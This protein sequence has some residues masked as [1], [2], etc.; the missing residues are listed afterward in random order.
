[1]MVSGIG[2]SGGSTSQLGGIEGVTTGAYIAVRH[3]RLA[4]QGMARLDWPEAFVP[5]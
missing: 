2:F 4:E 3:G 1:M 5:G